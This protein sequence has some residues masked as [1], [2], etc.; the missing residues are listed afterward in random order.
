MA[1]VWSWDNKIGEATFKQK[2]GDGDWEEHTCNMY[3][4]N[5]LLILIHEWTEG[6][7]EKYNLV[8]FF[9]DKEHARRCLGLDKRHKDTYNSWCTDYDRLIKVRINKAKSHNYKDII[10]LLLQAFD[11]IDIEIFKEE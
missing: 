9:A 4:G 7:S 6:T 11:N 5:A 2:R 8:G 10:N 1:L 3:E